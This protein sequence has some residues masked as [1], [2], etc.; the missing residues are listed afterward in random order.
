MAESLAASFSL[1]QDSNDLNK[2]EI[3]VALQR[4]QQQLKPAERAYME[5]MAS[6]ANSA[7]GETSTLGDDTLNYSVT[8]KSSRPEGD[9]LVDSVSRSQLPNYFNRG[10]QDD[11]D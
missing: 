6:K 3:A 5:G 11:T 10:G 8:Q 9:Q 7:A 1:S 4:S 2:R